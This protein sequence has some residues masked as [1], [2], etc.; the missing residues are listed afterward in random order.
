M[1]LV[2]W[3]HVVLDGSTSD[4]ASAF[5]AGALD[6]SWRSAAPGAGLAA[7]LVLADGDTY[8]HRAGRGS[9]APALV[10]EVED[11]GASTQRVLALGA[12]RPGP[13]PGGLRSPGGLAFGLIQAHEHRRAPAVQWPDGT[14]S[15]LV[16]LCLD[17]PPTR[18]QAEAEF[19][20]DVTGWAWEESQDEFVCHLVPGAGS[21]QLLVQRRASALPAEVTLHLD[22]GTSD[23]EAEAVRLTALGAERVATGGGWIVLTDPDGRRFCATGQPPEAP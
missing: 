15:R 22:L 4:A 11:V 16:Q 1:D 10:L 17:C 12:T 7:S 20:R 2:T 6:G 13:G 3:T 14:S 9:V 23:R 5:W 21:L 19:W 18:A 8:V